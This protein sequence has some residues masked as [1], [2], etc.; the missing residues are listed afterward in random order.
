MS[1]KV[2]IWNRRAEDLW[3]VRQDEAVDE[4][5]LSL[6]MGLPTERVAPAL[7]AVLSRSSERERLDLEAVNRRG[8]AIVCSTTVLPL[9]SASADADGRLRGAIV[10]MEDIP[11]GDGDAS[12]DGAGTDGKAVAADE[13]GE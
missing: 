8:R 10:L 9:T 12:S 5:F 6:D 11:A 3:G 2:Q 4:H 13:A 1:G 7:R